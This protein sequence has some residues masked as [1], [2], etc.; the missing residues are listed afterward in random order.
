MSKSPA[1]Q[2]YPKQWLGDN[3]VILMDWDA[4]AMHLHLM[5]IAWQMEIPCTL[6]DDDEILQKFVGN[7]NGWERL[8]KQIFR[9]WRLENGLWIQDGLAR[10]HQKQL[11]NSDKRRL[12]AAARW[13]QNQE[14]CKSNADAMQMQC[15]SITISTADTIKKKPLLRNGKKESHAVSLPADYTYNDK[16][17]ERAKELA[18]DVNFQFEKFKTHNQASGKKYINW[19]AAFQNWLL[20]AKEFQQQQNTK[21]T[22]GTHAAYPQRR[23]SSSQIFSESIRGSINAL[24]SS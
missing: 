2:F 12:A 24:N 9:A 14:S 10:E 15:S 22:G 23:K 8:K 19:D 7:P 1:F 4:R 3:N 20:K 16:H 6:P 5:C 18:L 21:I 11:D 17:T 13:Q